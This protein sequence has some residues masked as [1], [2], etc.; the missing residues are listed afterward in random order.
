[1]H[2]D[3]LML[4]AQYWEGR[5]QTEQTGWDIGSI[6]TPIKNFLDLL[7][8]KELKILFPGAG[9][10]H[11]AEY[12]NKL[13][14]ENVFV[15]DFA[16][17]ALDDFK[18]RVPAFPDECLIHGDF[19]ELEGQFDLVIEQTFFCALNPQLRESYAEKMAG[20]LKGDGR[21]VG[22]FF[23]TEFEKQGPPF[24]GNVTDYHQLF[25]KYF[26]KVQFKESK[27]SIGPRLGKEVWGEISR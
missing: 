15:L 9:R 5:Y 20:I 10:A 16:K 12:A 22:L 8:N 18:K 17:S 13:G 4:D 11:E 1:M 19:F 3:I 24:G 14:F 21:L 26:S 27:D 7:E 6:S 2:K 23:N 25:S